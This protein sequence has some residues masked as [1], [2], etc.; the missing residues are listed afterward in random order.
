MVTQKTRKFLRFLGLTAASAA[1]PKSIIFLHEQ[2]DESKNESREKKIWY[3][4]IEGMGAKK[5]G[6]RKEGRNERSTT[7]MLHGETYW[8]G[9]SGGQY[10]WSGEPHVASSYE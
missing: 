10:R 2:P 8:G 6:T 5:K 9:T 4:G 1:F 3:G 7:P